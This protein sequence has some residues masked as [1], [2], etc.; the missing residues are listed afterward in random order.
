MFN[1]C[2]SSRRVQVKGPGFRLS[3]LFLFVF[4]GLNSPLQHQQIVSLPVLMNIVDYFG[5]LVEGELNQ[6]NTGILVPE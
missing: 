1:T 6:E 3:L 4:S 2:P 5:E